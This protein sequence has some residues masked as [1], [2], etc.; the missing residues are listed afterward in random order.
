[1][2]IRA[3]AKRRGAALVDV[4]GLTLRA[5]VDPATGTWAALPR[6]TAKG[7]HQTRP[8]HTPVRGIAKPPR[9]DRIQ[10]RGL[11]RVRP[12]GRVRWPLGIEE[13]RPPGPMR[14]RIAGKVLH[15]R[16][17]VEA[18]AFMY[19]RGASGGTG[20]LNPLCPS[21]A[22]RRISRRCSGRER[23]PRSLRQ[24][25][26]LGALPKAYRR[27]MTQIT[28]GS[29]RGGKTPQVGWTSPGTSAISVRRSIAT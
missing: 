16:G 24:Q 7:N 11:R 17:S 14:L 6:V 5:A 15:R 23:N 19:A 9:R 1:M 28:F 13:R 18:L 22:I 2:A 3:P 4:A 20:A 29:N 10:L 8:V 12:A 26:R 21:K 25:S 27:E